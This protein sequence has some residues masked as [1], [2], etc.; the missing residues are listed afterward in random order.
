MIHRHPTSP[1]LF[2]GDGASNRQGLR[3]CLMAPLP[4]LLQAVGGSGVLRRS[5]HGADHYRS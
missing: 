1:S 5:S 4:E 3:V 2:S